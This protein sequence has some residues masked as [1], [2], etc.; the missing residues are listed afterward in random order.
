M[1]WIETKT[2]NDAREVQRAKWLVVATENGDGW[3]ATLEGGH[4][5]EDGVFWADACK[6][7]KGYPRERLAIAIRQMPLPAAFKE[8]CIS[9]RA[10]IREARKHEI[11]Y[12]EHLSRLHFY[13]AVSS[14]C[15]PYSETLQTP[16]FN[17]FESIP[18]SVFESRMNL[19]WHQIG[20]KSLGLLNKTD[21]S[22][23]LELW[24]EPDRQRSTHELYSSVWLEYEDKWRKHKDASRGIFD[25]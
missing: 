2:D 20:Y 24:G 7:L 17:I 15:L 25:I 8:A 22:W 10:L 4:F 11:D 1:L 12:R 23:M 5:Y 18:Y 14:F 19:S 21:A 6:K 13:A 3:S 9:L 16:G